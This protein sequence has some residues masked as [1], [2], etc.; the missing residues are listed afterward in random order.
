MNEEAS[1]DRAA[2]HRWGMDNRIAEDGIFSSPQAISIGNGIVMKEGYWFNVV[3][4]HYG[5][6]PKIT[7]ADNCRLDRHVQL[8]AIH[9]V[10][11]EQNVI[12]GPNVYIAD[13][14]HEY[15]EVGISIRHQ[16]VNAFGQSVRVG[17]GTRIGPNCVIVGNVNIGEHCIIAPNS[18]VVRD[19]P[20][21]SLAGGAPA[22]L[23]RSVPSLGG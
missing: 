15:R 21:Y 17:K 7:V 18:V 16:W 14:D 4:A 22:R 13:T 2:F 20:A 19:I 23:I 1:A 6:L 3:N 8:T 12:V 5:Q 10:I 9:S 11:L